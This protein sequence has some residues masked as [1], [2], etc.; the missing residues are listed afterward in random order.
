[1]KRWPLRW[2]LALL[3]ATLVVVVLFCVG[4]AAC[5]QLNRQGVHDL[6]HELRHVAREFFI[7]YSEMPAINWS[8]RLTVRSLMAT[9]HYAYFLEVHD[10]HDKLLFRS[11]GTPD[12]GVPSLGD[13][14]ETIRTIHYNG[15]LVRV[16]NFTQGKMRLRL[17]MDL[18]VVERTQADLIQCFLLATPFLL[19]FVG[20]GGW[21]VARRALAPIKQMAESAEHISA[22]RLDQRLPLPETG[23][24]IE[25]LTVVLN[26]MFDRLEASFQ[27][28]T[29][30]TADAS[31]ELKTP[32]TVIRGELEAA[33]RSGQFEPVQEKLLVNLMEETERLS[34]ISEGL[35][36][37]SRADSGRLALALKPVDLIPLMQDLL[38][39]AEIL[40][41]PQRITVDSRLP[42]SAWIQGSPQ[43]LRQLLLNLLDNAIKY[44]EEGGRVSISVVE[45]GGCWS[46]RVGNTGPGIRPEDEEHVF[47]RF[48][49]GDQSRSQQK[50]HGLGLSICREIVRAHGG[51]M[52]LDIS[53][54]GWTQFQVNLVKAEGEAEDNQTIGQSDNRSSAGRAF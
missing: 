9:T 53:R 46:I 42:S 36:L 45:Q 16:G 28:A 21:F 22:Q 34:Q 25:R 2:Q 7:T 44:N 23:D 41:T 31:H 19:G 40:A 10:E 32:L 29:R 15:H 48:F 5:W 51:E 27:Q 4:A 17:L 3:T 1:M 11:R 13:G 18:H 52:G 37:L 26:H 38:E 12:E 47:D 24:E 30:F 20:F 43:F 8:D 54:P 33:L 49:R 14:R 39:D 50:G 35:L 6:D